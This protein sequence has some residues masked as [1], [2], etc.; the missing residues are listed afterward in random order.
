MKNIIIMD[1]NGVQM[2]R[3]SFTIG[4]R[5][6][7]FDDLCVQT[8][9][10]FNELFPECPVKGFDNGAALDIL[11]PAS[12]NSRVLNINGLEVVHKM[13]SDLLYNVDRDE[14]NMEECEDILGIPV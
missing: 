1:L 11:Y 12:N 13:Y 14:Y 8:V 10:T 4:T 3:Q 6:N 9:G 5:I 7:Q 2:N